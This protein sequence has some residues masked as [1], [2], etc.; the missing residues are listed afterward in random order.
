MH[1]GFTFILVN[2]TQEKE[3]D[4]RKDDFISTAT[5]ELKTPITSMRLFAEIVEKQTEQSGDRVALESV[6]E[7]NVQLD[8]L[9][10]LMNYLLDVAKVQQGRLELNKTFFDVNQFIE[11][12]I[13]MVKSVSKERT[14]NFIKDKNKKDIYADRERLGQVLTNLISNSV[15]YS[16]KENE[17]IVK[18]SHIKDN[19]IISVQDFGKGI[20]EA[21]QKLIFNRFYRANSAIDSHIS[22][23][24]LGLYVAM[25]IVRAH[26]GR[27]WVKS[28]K[29][30]GST[31]YLSIP[32]K[33]KKK[34]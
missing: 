15:K 9:T 22:G 16:A 3:L 4:K 34:P 1:R 18:S 13:L 25:Q 27:M 23:I 20:P 33:V 10:A 26:H 24:G 21:E 2:R 12:V 6:R 14:I 32:M 30:K 17:I 19:I 29:D 7:L 11:G 5:H 28:S 8:R 31:F